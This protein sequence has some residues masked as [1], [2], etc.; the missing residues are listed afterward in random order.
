[1]IKLAVLLLTATT[2]IF[3]ILPGLKITPIVSLEKVYKTYPT[4]H[5]KTV[6]SL[7]LR[8]S[9]GPS[10]LAL[11]IEATRY[12][13]TEDFVTQDLKI[14]DESY[15]GKLGLSSTFLKITGLNFTLRAGGSARKTT[16]TRTESGTTI[17][18]KPAVKIS[19]YAGVDLAF[20]MIPGVSIIIGHNIIFTGEPKGSDVDSQTSFGLT[21]GI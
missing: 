1:M 9:M 15:Q 18:Y 5:S 20:K 19:P 17:K 8:T 12:S 3:A 2:S 6:T 14:E 16:E 4:T 7:G 10:L 13:D 21:I 11:E